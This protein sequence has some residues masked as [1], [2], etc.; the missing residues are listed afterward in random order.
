MNLNIEELNNALII[1][2][3]EYK[4]KLL[5]FL[6]ESKKIV[7]VNFMSLQEY[8]KNYLFDYKVDAIKHLVDNGL[9]PE[10]AKEILDNIVYVEDKDYGNK[11][12]NLLVKYKKELENSN[13]LIYN[14]L[15]KQYIKNKDVIV[16]GY[17]KLLN[18]YINL[19]EGKTVKIIEDEIINR[20]YEINEF[21]DIEEEV[22]F[23]YNSIF[24]LLEK[25]TDINDIY[26]LN[27]S[28]EYDSYIKRYN[29][30]YNFEIDSCNET[31][32]IGTELAQ[33]FIEMIDTKT[34]DEIYE[35]LSNFENEISLKLTNILNKYVEYDLNEVKDLLIDDVRKTKIKYN[36]KN[37]V[38]CVNVNYPFDKKDFVFAIG[39]SDTFLSTK[40][41]L[42]YINDSIRPLVGL[43]LCEEENI[44]KKQNLLSKLSNIDNLILSYSKNSPFKAHNKQILFTSD[45]CKYKLNNQNYDYS[46]KLNKAKYTDKLDKLRKFNVF[47]DGIEELNKKYGRND[48][49]TYNNKFKGLSNN[50][51]E[52]ITKT[53]NDRNE[54]L[55]L[56]YSSM[57]KFNECSFKYYLDNVL[58]IDNNDST[59]NTII[60]NVCHAVLKDLYTDDA[61]D[62]D[63][64]WNKQI[65]NEEEKEGSKLFENESEEFFANNIKE[66]LRKDI[67]IVKKQKE[68][69][70][71]DKQYCEKNYFYKL[72]DKISF[73]GFVDKLMF[74]ET[75]N[76]IL[77]SVVDY[78]TSRKIE[79]D[80]DIMKYGLSLQLPSYL[81][82]IKHSNE[83]SKEVKFTGLYI[84]HLINFDRKY[85]DK[86]PSL[87]TTKADSMK[88]DGLSSSSEERM[89]AMDITLDNGKKSESISNISIKKAGGLGSSSRLCSDEE[90]VTLDKYVE[91]SIL[92]AGN[93]ILNGDF[94][95]NPKEID[96]ENK[97]CTY[98]K[99]A[100][101]CYRRNSDLKYID[102]K[103]E[104]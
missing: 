38:K 75:D 9:S 79:I 28:S 77:A 99:Y 44:I 2:P 5:S 8:C 15:F 1:C 27:N 16:F 95:I 24:D 78:K 82:L 87:E 3:N 53:I 37:V 81:F 93:A 18:Y 30:Y 98:C 71:L 4:E 50:Q 56:S 84:Q 90:F 72:N 34:K 60:G 65:K 17:G 73:I 51:I 70:L 57:N 100:A 13:L 7:N 33:E 29:T 80:K 76:E 40:Q 58:K 59:Y 36:Y 96:G 52:N 88:L 35:Y 22:E 32:I 67:E 61:F 6:S 12:L 45:I 91:N 11:K 69:S 74:K 21:N 31:K 92:E 86:N 101:I 47:Q 19:I 20:K 14:K 10:N 23:V 49:L 97:S 64:S 48:Y 62:F 41:D 26:V 104:Q 66:E 103:E 85:N 39:F 94:S 46:E 83:F 43:P 54:I 42:E 68:N 89:R 25:G 102:T 55:K 63:F